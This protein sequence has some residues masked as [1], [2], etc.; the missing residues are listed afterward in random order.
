VERHLLQDSVATVRVMAAHAIAR[1]GEVGAT[2]A[3]TVR[4]L[5]PLLDDASATVRTAAVVALGA[6]G[7]TDGAAADALRALQADPDSL[8][9]REAA[10]ALARFHQRGG[11]DPR[12][13]EPSRVERCRTAPRGAP[14][15]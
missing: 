10:H 15:C 11:L 1:L 8:V 9:R 14:D 2:R 3:A 6:V 13:A 4:A 12:P 7:G 5:I